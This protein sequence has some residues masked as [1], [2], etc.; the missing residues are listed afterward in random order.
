MRS[1]PI[2]TPKEMK[3][4]CRNFWS[5][6]SSLLQDKHIPKCTL[7]I[8]TV[9]TNCFMSTLLQQSLRRKV[10]S[11]VVATY[12]PSRSSLRPSSSRTFSTT[13]GPFHFSVIES[14]S[15][16]SHSS[17]IVF[18]HGLLGNGKNLRTF[19]RELCRKQQ[20]RGILVDLPGHGSSKHCLE[21]TTS[22]E[23][24]LSGL[25]QTLQATGIDE[26]NMPWS[27]VGH[28]M[29]GR[30]ALQYANQFDTF[31]QPKRL[32]LL[33]TVPGGLNASVMHVMAVAEKLLPILQ[34]KNF[35]RKE[36]VHNLTSEHGID[37]ATAQWLGG[38]YDT[39]TREFYFS[40]A[41]AKNLVQC[42]FEHGNSD[43]T[44]V[45][46]FVEA[47][48]RILKQNSKVQRIDLV[49]GGKNSSWNSVKEQVLQLE[50][51]EKLP[52]GGS[53][54][55]VHLLPNAAHWVHIDDLSGLIKVLE[56]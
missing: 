16:T 18:L 8:I 53:Q 13:L 38:S 27:L 37:V 7:H 51:L 3:K 52:P 14:E 41:G 34:E 11:F 49:R 21:A 12:C 22:I 23:K 20:A 4:N 17:T 36:L 30:I 46:S 28:S 43:R 10:S 31:P 45:P 42:F 2:A 5:F 1:C 29:G 24:C 19:A 9:T 55:R 26:R 25:Y 48:E 54:L 35:T 44:G 33:D 50:A 15:P 56:S 47:I 40:L 32:I 6:C 39:Q